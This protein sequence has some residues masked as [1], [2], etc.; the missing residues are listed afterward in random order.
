MFK[1]SNAHWRYCLLLF[2]TTLLLGCGNVDDESGGSVE[3]VIGE[4]VYTGTHARPSAIDA[5]GATRIYYH[6]GDGN[7]HE[8]YHSYNTTG[9]HDYKMLS[10]R[11]ISGNPS[12]A[13]NGSTLKVFY[14]DAGTGTLQVLSLGSSWSVFDTRLHIEGD[15]AGGRDGASPYAFRDTDGSV[16]VFYKGTNAY[17]HELVLNG[18]SGVDSQ[19]GNGR[20]FEGTPSA[21]YN[22]GYL[23]VFYNDAVTQTLQNFYRV[24]GVWHSSNTGIRTA[25]GAS[26]VATRDLTGQT[27]VYF[28]GPDGYLHEADW[29][30]SRWVDW[31][32]NGGR[33]IEGNPSVAY[34]SGY[35]NVFY[36]DR[37]TSTLQL[38]YLNGSWLRA[39]TGFRMP[40]GSDPVALEDAF[41]ENAGVYYRSS[42]DDLH[43][44]YFNGVTWQ[45]TRIGTTIMWP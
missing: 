29:N 4:V 6:A 42:I 20:L 17:L 25:V 18:S 13:V 2:G 24:N 3:A 12:A 36:N 19:M 40:T 31:V 1:R 32:M 43:D 28:A 5:S 33:P 14:N 45:D 30:G 15:F 10:G 35:L 26:P 9:W 16:H 7:L 41:D 11:A 22:T 38:M 21:A 34:N 37:S 39:N 27:R 8:T 23:N 44:A